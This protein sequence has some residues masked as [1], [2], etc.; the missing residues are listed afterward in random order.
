MSH[1]T[2]RTDPAYMPTATAMTSAV[3][4][5]DSTDPIDRSAGHSISQLAA[6]WTVRPR[7]PSWHRLNLESFGRNHICPNKHR[8]QQPNAAT[9]TGLKKHRPITVTDR[10]LHRIARRQTQPQISHKSTG[11]MSPNGW[12]R[13][14]RTT[15]SRSRAARPTTRRYPSASFA[16][17]RTYHPPLPLGR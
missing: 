17:G 5:H 8:G 10:P 9:I 1:F 7:V 15:A 16:L 2:P 14:I 13:W 11:R 12:G 6:N 3:T 4:R